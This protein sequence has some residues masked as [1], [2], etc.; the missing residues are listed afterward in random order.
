M[1]AGN[2]AIVDVVQSQPPVLTVTAASIAGVAEELTAYHAAFAPEF[3]YRTQ[4][5]WSE[6][7]LRGLLVADVPRKNV[8]AVALRLLGA[9]EAAD[10][11]VRALQHFVSEGAWDDTAVLLRHWGLVDA[12]MGED[13]GVL[14]VDGSDLPKQGTHSAGVARQYCGVL[15]KKANCQAGVF[16]GY[17]SRR[18]Y[19]L[20]DRRLYLPELW[21]SPAYQDRWQAAAIPPETPFATKPALAAEMVEAIVASKQLRARWL[22][23]DE[24]FGNDPVFLDRIAACGLT[25]LAEVSRSTHVWP[26]VAPDG[27]TAR[28]APTVWVPPPSSTKGPVPTRERL[29]PESPASQALVAYAAA[30]PATAWQRYRI[31]EG[32]KGPLLADFVAV[33]VVAVRDRLPG[34]TVW[35]LIRRTLPEPGADPVYKFY[36]SNAS[37]DLP[38]LALVWASGMRW[39]I[40]RCFTEGKDELGLDHYEC[41]FWRGWHHHMTLVIL[42]HHFLVRLQGRLNQREG[43]PRTDQLA[44][45]RSA[46]DRP[47]H[48]LSPAGPG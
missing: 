2:A 19:T 11:E 36:L 28:A 3:A 43:G 30:V 46:A 4:A 41:R 45:G 24:G 6:L 40:E 12:Q 29:Q 31:L 27:Q 37:A 16:V 20:L 21:F 23:C 38:L 25:Y 5:R 14:T 32:A 7:Y 48:H 26:L 22:T 8:E 10:R 13:D 44:P 39:P 47:G 17:A 33:R 42:A 34:P 9:G 18:G 1:V 35:L 15:G